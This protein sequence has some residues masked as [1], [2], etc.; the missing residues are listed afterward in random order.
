MDKKE[1][2]KNIKDGVK[3]YANGYNIAIDVALLAAGIKLHN[4]KLIIGAAI[5]TAG[6]AINIYD[7]AVKPLIDGVKEEI[8][9]RKTE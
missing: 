7:S 3:G 8:E 1:L 4:R 2:I 6:T 5:A 9:F